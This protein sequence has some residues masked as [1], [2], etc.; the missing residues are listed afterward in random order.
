M[1]ISKDWLFQTVI[2]ILLSLLC[3]FGAQIWSKQA[4]FDCRLRT[5]ELQN[6]RIMERMGIKETAFLTDIPP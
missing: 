1:S 4:D 5:L 2:T 3:F 6:A